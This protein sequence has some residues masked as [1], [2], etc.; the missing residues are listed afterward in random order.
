MLGATG[1]GSDECE[2][3]ACRW[4]G[5]YRPAGV[6]LRPISGSEAVPAESRPTQPPTDLAAMLVFLGR[7]LDPG[8]QAVFASRTIFSGRLFTAA[9]P[10]SSTAPA[11]HNGGSHQWQCQAVPMAANA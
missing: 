10:L 4:A 2:E 1:S 8:L 9:A 7:P 5:L 11:T 3:R 6:A